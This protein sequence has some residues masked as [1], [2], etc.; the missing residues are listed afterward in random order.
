MTD[1]PFKMKGHS[2]PGPNQASP[3]KHTTA[4]QRL[5][6]GGEHTHTKEKTKERKVKIAD[7]RDKED[8][9]LGKKK[10]KLKATMTSNKK[11]IEKKRT[12]TDETKMKPPYRKPVGPVAD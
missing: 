12:I 4:A 6:V 8:P 7:L 11:P 9:Q 3:A 1:T 10:G 2:L 5:G